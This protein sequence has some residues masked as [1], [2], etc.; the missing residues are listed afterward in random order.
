MPWKLG[1]RGKLDTAWHELSQAL[2]QAGRRP[3]SNQLGQ[4]RI[5][6]LLFT[7]TITLLNSKGGSAVV[8]RRRFRVT[9]RLDNAC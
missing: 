1:K 9:E 2:G 8:E 3:T 6:K 5:L 4:Q 7:I